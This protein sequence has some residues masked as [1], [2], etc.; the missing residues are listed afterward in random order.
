[1]KAA[2][3]EMIA[4]GMPADAMAVFEDVTDLPYA[5]AGQGDPGLDSVDPLAAER[6][7]TDLANR[8]RENYLKAAALAKMHS[9][10]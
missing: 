10:R 1:M 7:A 4:A 2:W 8:F 9:A 3:R 5:V 6:R